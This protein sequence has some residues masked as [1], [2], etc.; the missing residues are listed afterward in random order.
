MTLHGNQIANLTHLSVHR[1][2]DNVAIIVFERLIEA[3]AEIVGFFSGSKAGTQHLATSRSLAAAEA[4][5]KVAIADLNIG[6]RL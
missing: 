3:L 6:F 1:T 2:I 4:A 5:D